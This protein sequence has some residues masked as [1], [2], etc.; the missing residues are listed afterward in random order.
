[1]GNPAAP[2]S[3]HADRRRLARACGAVVMAI[4]ITGNA[5]LARDD[6]LRLPELG[7]PASQVLSLTEEQRLG[8][9][10]MR[11]VRQRAPMVDDPQVRQYVRDLGVRLVSR[12]NTGG[13]SYEF[14]VVN[15]PAINAFAMP[16][17][18]IG[19][20]RGLITA[21]QSE[22][23]LASVLAHEIAHVTQRHIA[24]RMADS[25]G[26]SLRTLGIMV[27]AILLGT[28]NSQM[29]SAAAIGGLAGS[30]QE[31]LNYS[32][33]HEREADNVGMQ[34]LASANL[35]PDGM[36]R[37]F[38]RLAESSRY[39]QRP[40][41][42]LST[43]PITES[44]I[45]ASRSRA[46]SMNTGD[47]EESPTFALMRAK[48]LVEGADQPAQAVTRFSPDGD[49]DLHD[50]L[51]ETARRYGLAIAHLENGDPET[52][53]EIVQTLL[54]EDDTHPA[55]LIAEAQTYAE[56]GAYDQALEP[57]Q[58]G[59]DLF[60]G[61][62]ALVVETARVMLRLDQPL[63]ARALVRRQIQRHGGD[64]TLH[65]LH[66]EAATEAGREHEGALALGEHYYHEGNLERALEQIRRV[67]NAGDAD[68]E[69][70]SRAV[71][72]QETI[73]RELEAMNRE[74]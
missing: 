18:Y 66:A 7:D 72:R 2:R 30:T 41:E 35:N 71:A 34:I 5:A 53:R 56:A 60:P 23:E 42:Y 32:R 16:G 9:R 19:I 28:Q 6:G 27:A 50:A 36:P 8:Q 51:G 13:M 29:G 58:L 40:P 70:R 3:R 43:H 21:T 4:A 55:F 57:L 62:Y 20:N 37:F 39:Q 10:L 38:E 46:S 67:A 17:G 68:V 31:R 22:S 49:A 52:A 47:P 74:M 15:S 69:Q 24:R 25:Q 26:S 59:L 54:E 45:A 44:R 14:F 64:G 48:L 61:D 11:Q 63:E 65:R 33:N 1:M 12:A 73:R